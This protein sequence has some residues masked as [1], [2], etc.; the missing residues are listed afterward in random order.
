MHLM[1]VVLPIFKLLIIFLDYIVYNIYNTIL[2][3]V[4][5]MKVVYTKKKNQFIFYS[6]NKFL[7][8]TPFT[9]LKNN[10]GAATVWT[11]HFFG[12][13]IP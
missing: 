9:P 7:V 1:V 4:Y 2:D 11:R 8:P 10:L 12:Y 13:K 6:H 3:F 5:N